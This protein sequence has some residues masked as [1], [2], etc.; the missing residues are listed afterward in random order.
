MIMD[1]RPDVFHTEQMS[2]ILHSV[3]Y[4][5]SDV[6]ITEHFTGFLPVK[7]TTGEVCDTV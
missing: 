1:C 6:S 2:V 5:T 7:S 3:A 4:E